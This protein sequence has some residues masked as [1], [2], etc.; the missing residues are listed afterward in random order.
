MHSSNI[1]LL[2]PLL[3][4]TVLLSWLLFLRLPSPGPPV[5]R[6]FFNISEA[7]IIALDDAEPLRH[8]AS[9]YLDVSHVHVF[10]AINGTE[11]VRL[12]FDSLPLYTKLLLEQ[13]ARH[14][15]MQLASGPMLGCLMSHIAVWRRIQPDTIV[16]VLEEDAVLDETSEDRI[17]ML[18]EDLRGQPWELLMLESGQATATGKWRYVGEV[19]AACAFRWQR[20]SSAVMRS[21]YSYYYNYYLLNSNGNETEICTWQGSRGYLLSYRGAQMLL[22]YSKP[23]MVQVDALMG[24][25]ATFE[26][27]FRMYWPRVDVVHKNMLRMSSIWDGCLKCYVPASPASALLLL[28]FL[29]FFTGV[30][31]KHHYY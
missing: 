28:A 20:P 10:D 15:H 23:M 2:W 19:A 25:V 27:E 1:R 30:F 31:I 6:H 4:A 18:S 13:G 8:K 9:T 11:A 7:Y 14:D 16:A 17:R 24:L 5:R 26:P 21:V 22:K 12:A 3:L 29:L